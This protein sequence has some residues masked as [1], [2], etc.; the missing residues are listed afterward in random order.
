M[1]SRL[2]FVLLSV[3]SVALVANTVTVK[4][5]AIGIAVS[6]VFL[7]LNSAAIGKLFFS[8]EVSFFRM[9]L[10]IGA[11]V[12]IIAFIGCVLVFA[13]IFTEKVSI[14]TLILLSFILLFFAAR[15][16]EPQLLKS[17][18][19]PRRVKG[20]TEDKTRPLVLVFFFSIAVAFYMLL[21]GRTSEGGASVWLTIPE[22]FIPVFLLV[23][24]F[25]G[26]IV[27]FSHL[28]D[29]S[30]LV[31]I[32]IFS[33]LVHSLLLVVW[34][35]G[36]Y[37]DPW[38]HLGHTRYV[39]KAG[40]PY[41]YGG[42]IQRGQFIDILKY[43]GMQ[44]LVVFF[45]RMFS[46]DIY[47]VFIVLVPL[48][49]SIFVPF[50]SYK[51][52]ESIT[53]RK[54][55]RFPLLAAMS[56]EIFSPLII[57]GAVATP[58]SLGF[59]FFF[60]MVTLLL[61]WMNRGSSRI[62]FLV[63]FTA[64]ACFLTHP[65]TGIFAFMLFF[66]GTLYQKF[67][68]RFLKILSYLFMFALYPFIMFFLGAGLNF[69]GLIVL[70]N[71]LSFQSMITTILLV[72]GLVGL[73]L[74]IKGKYV[75]AE[76]AL[77]LFVFYVT[78]LFE[79]YFM[80][81]GM[82]NW[83]FGP[84]RMLPMGDLLLAPFVSLGLVTV[85]DTLSNA[86]PRFSASVFRR[87]VSIS[88]DPRLIGAL[89]ICLFFSLQATSSLY[90]AYPREEIVKVQPAGYEI[91]AAYY[92]SST[93]DRSYVVL[94]SPTF[95]SLATAFLGADYA[96]YGGV[97]GWFGVSAWGYPTQLLYL[98]M[99]RNPSIS[100]MKE[101]MSYINAEVAY[102]VVSV[103]E[104]NFE[105]IVQQTS[106]ILPV[107][108]IF[109]N[110]KLYVFKY[111]LPIIEE[112]GPNVKVVFDEGASADYIS[113]NVSYMFRAEANISVTVSGHSSYNI[114]DYPLAWTFHDLTV[115]NASASFDES[116]NVNAFI[117]K[118]GLSPKDVLKVT[119]FSNLNYPDAGWKED[120]F[121]L[122]RWQRLTGTIAPDIATDGNILSMSWNFTPGEY[123]PYYYGRVC[124]VSTN[125]YRYIMVRWKS[126]AKIAIAAV[127]FE[128][129]VA[130]EGQTIVWSGSGSTDWTLTILELKPDKRIR[131]VMVGITNI[132]NTD[133]SGLQ[134]LYVDFILIG[135]RA[136]E[137]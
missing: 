83:P 52:A 104:P 103:R 97:S 124:N 41:G 32:S 51:N 84:G 87:R 115:N 117:Y 48:L 81:Y 134:T 70:D 28:S 39:A 80:T 17:T 37:G 89:L 5:M 88:V 42:L 122:S 78:V 4:S 71:Y 12:S 63:M 64:A 3:L 107:D 93:I 127:Y 74:G 43:R 129:K 38:T 132:Y 137:D 75:S 82:T 23:S 125:D 16:Q 35:P 65:G 79:Y 118:S 19:N 120:S 13:G 47:W 135:N 92:I 96:Y 98:E 9:M 128:S 121:E 25:L 113:T 30:K 77:M 66:W 54:N 99:T 8:N 46:V 68:S 105:K 108:R 86:T 85:A 10:G 119:W 49:W 29:A 112:V 1:N 11:F 55:S 50:L 34:Y 6:L 131:S 59:L 53:M 106:D 60:L 61:Y 7:Y 67:T 15:T 21:I 114:T 100:K 91:E 36:R 136:I 111:P 101:G 116:S 58:N 27:L 90:S 110:G 130:S 22:F 26:I 102:F 44:V 62:W 14:A 40:M 126:T 56:T 94:C 123:Q 95:A 31:L 18:R 76:K 109:G 73:V 20:K 69:A 33:F 2:R 24:L 133:M 57:W 45:E 72:L